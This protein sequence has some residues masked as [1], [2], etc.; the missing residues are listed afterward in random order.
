VIP[1]PIATTTST[2][3][4]PSPVEGDFALILNTPAA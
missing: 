2:A 1:A 3:R 4:M